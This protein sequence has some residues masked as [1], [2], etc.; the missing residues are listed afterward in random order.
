MVPEFQPPGL[1]FDLPRIRNSS[2]PCSDPK[3]KEL[4]ARCVQD[5]PQAYGVDSLLVRPMWSVS[6][7]SSSLWLIMQ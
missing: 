3:F 5:E 4:A 2:T 7:Y 6:K 1:S